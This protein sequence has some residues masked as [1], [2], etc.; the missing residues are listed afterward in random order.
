MRKEI[1]LFQKE[2]EKWKPDELKDFIIEG[3]DCLKK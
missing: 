3:L 2:L 1:E